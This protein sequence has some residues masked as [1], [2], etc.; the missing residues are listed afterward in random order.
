MSQFVRTGSSPKYLYNEK[1][2]FNCKKLIG[3][4]LT[5]VYILAK[6]LNL[7]LFF[8][9]TNQFRFRGPQIIEGT[10]EDGSLFWC[11]GIPPYVDPHIYFSYDY[12]PWKCWNNETQW[13]RTIVICEKPIMAS[14]RLL[15]SFGE[16]AK[17][18]FYSDTFIGTELISSPTL[19]SLN[20]VPNSY[21]T[22][23]LALA[24]KL[25][26]VYDTAVMQIIHP[27]YF[28]SDPLTM[29][30]N[31]DF[32]KIIYSPEPALAQVPFDLNHL[33]FLINNKIIK[34]TILMLNALNGQ[35]G[36]R[37]QIE[38]WQFLNIAR[39]LNSIME[40]RRIIEEPLLETVV[41][42]YVYKFNQDIILPDEKIILVN[43]NLA[44]DVDSLLSVA[45]APKSTSIGTSNGP[46]SI[47]I[48]GIKFWRLSIAHI[49]KYPAHIIPLALNLILRGKQ[50]KIQ[51]SFEGP[52][53]LK[54]NRSYKLMHRLSETCKCKNK[55]ILL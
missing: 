18:F 16:T 40:Y 3:S 21:N 48:Q 54:T 30:S 44:P 22:T 45:L 9:V 8:H 55:G 39:D 32:A 5:A 12:H 17:D 51:E 24:S 11:L 26:N 1:L 43:N 41:E 33:T 6:R 27:T 37:L 36:A 23:L 28:G 34:N 52:P 31:G 29:V 47:L 50:T 35:G 10:H 7:Q 13:T 4:H 25:V 53:E 14:I 46:A 20:F 2:N 38:P 19:K 42:G 49:E 15:N